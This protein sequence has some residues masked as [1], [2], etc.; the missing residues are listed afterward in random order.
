MGV[1]K[2]G[3]PVLGNFP[4]NLCVASPLTSQKANLISKT[5]DMSRGKGVCRG[6]KRPGCIGVAQPNVV[7]TSKNPILFCLHFYLAA[8]VEHQAKLIAELSEKRT[9]HGVQDMSCFPI[10]LGENLPHT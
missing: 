7:T 10:H 3:T 9:A 4:L 5:G 1:F 6:C 2:R 8:R